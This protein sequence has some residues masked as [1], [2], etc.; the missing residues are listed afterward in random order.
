MDRER[1]REKKREGEGE[2]GIGGERE[3]DREKER[4]FL[5]VCNVRISNTSRITSSTYYKKIEENEILSSLDFFKISI[6]IYLNKLYFFPTGNC[7]TAW[8]WRICVSKPGS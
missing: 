4:V 2:R 1:E 6:Q 8:L 5:R 7:P 3:R